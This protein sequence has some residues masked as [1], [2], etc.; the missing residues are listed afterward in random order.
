MIS[1]VQPVTASRRIRHLLTVI[2]DS[3]STADSSQVAALDPLQH[4]W[5]CVC[6]VLTAHFWC[7]T[8]Q[9]VDFDDPQIF[10][11]RKD[12]QVPFLDFIKHAF[13]FSRT[14]TWRPIRD[15]SHWLDFTIHGHSPVFSHIHNLV[16]LSFIVLGFCHLADR[17]KF[18]RHWSYIAITLAFV[19]PVQV[20]TVAWISGRKDLLATLFMLLS[21]IS[22]ER[23]LESQRQW[24]NFGITLTCFILS[25]LSKGHMVVLPV[26]YVCLW[27]LKT[28]GRI[29]ALRK[30]PRGRLSVILITSCISL[31]LANRIS[32]GG[33]SLTNELMSSERYGITLLDKVQL[34]IRYLSH[35]FWP[36]DLNHV[37]L[38]HVASGLQYSLATASIL[39]T[40]AFVILMHR[41]WIHGSLLGP[42]MMCFATLM[43]PY[44]HLKPGVVYMADRYLFSALPF[45]FLGIAYQI[46]IMGVSQLFS[47]RINRFATFA[48]MATC[49]VL[50]IQPHVAF[51]N[52]ISL[53]SRM[54]EVY[55]QSA[56]GLN[57]LGQALYRRGD[58]KAATGAWLKAAS[59]RPDDPQYL[60]NAAVSAMATGHF[61]LAKDIILKAQ[62]RHPEDPFVKKN[63]RSLEYLKKNI[64]TPKSGKRKIFP[65]ENTE[66]EA[67]D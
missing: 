7:L 47:K 9:F 46:S 22:F 28:P 53:W 45:L 56:W 55:P 37:Y 54:A 20:E 51:S 30:A 15:L 63:I 65:L 59:Y 3:K 14:D 41:F 52:S 61:E 13:D 62:S 2:P 27:Q 67:L 4:K 43:L 6:I 16:L 26:L 8:S 19:H 44:M 36:L 66:H 48:L 31:L 18:S 33:I 23:I 42:I 5:V 21:L 32:G 39:L 10:L 11:Q 35:I 24:L 29:S 58:M 38:T 50:C 34:P 60:N 57:R 64:M 1:S 12:L 17:L 49:A 40:I 25:V